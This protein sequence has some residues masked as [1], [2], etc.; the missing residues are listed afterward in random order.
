MDGYFT[1]GQ[2]LIDVHRAMVNILENFWLLRN[3]KAFPK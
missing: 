2:I 1:I 3:F